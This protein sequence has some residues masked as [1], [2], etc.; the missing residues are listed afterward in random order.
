MKSMCG[1]IC[2]EPI[3]VFVLDLHETSHETFLTSAVDALHSDDI[4][5][6]EGLRHGGQP[7]RHRHAVIV[8]EQDDRPASFQ[9][10]AIARR[11]GSGIRLS[12][13]TNAE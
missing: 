6:S 12:D 5:I 4:R 10:A 13:E 1:T 11:R 3:F 2:H 9:G 7:V 8:G